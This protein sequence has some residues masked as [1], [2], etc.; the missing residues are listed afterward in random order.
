MLSFPSP[1][2]VHVLKCKRGV[3]GSERL[4]VSVPFRGSR[5]EI[6]ELSDMENSFSKALFPSPFGVH[7]LKL[8]RAA[9][10]FDS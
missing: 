4:E 8:A 1:F 3:A 5:S 6:R 2:G 9:V 7:V 10:V